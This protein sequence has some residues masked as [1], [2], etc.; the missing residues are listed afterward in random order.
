MNQA[1]KR[2]IEI[3]KKMTPDKIL[4]KKI[5]STELIT[6]FN[7]GF[8]TGWAMCLPE[9]FKEALDI[10]FT[11]RIKKGVKEW[12]WTQGS[13]FYFKEGD[14]IYNTK[15]AYKGL[16]RE[17]LNRI[18]VCFQVVKAKPAEPAT[19][20]NRRKNIPAKNR[21]P[22]LVEYIELYPDKAKTKLEKSGEIKS[23]TQDAFIEI[24]ILGNP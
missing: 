6:E 14:T 10:K 1:Q 7:D 11:V 22:G 3:L 12:V 8:S 24:L 9:A 15:E 19:A 13:Q 23:V 17:S 16:W 2:S 4:K 18:A 21:F 5:R 20:P